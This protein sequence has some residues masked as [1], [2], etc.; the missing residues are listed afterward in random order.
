M[1]CVKSVTYNF[2]ANDT[3]VGPVLP[4]RGLRQGDPLSPYIFILCAEGSSI[5]LKQANR[6]GSLNGSRVCRS[7]PSI[8]H[9]H[10][11]DDCLLFC[12]ADCEQCTTLKN[13]LD[14]YE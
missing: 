9:L 5:L 10:F 3:L 8:S 11:V 6:E 14:I 13:I 1:L 12:R 4:T 7:A 2:V